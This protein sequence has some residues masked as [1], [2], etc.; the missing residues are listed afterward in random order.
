[1]YFYSVSEITIANTFILYLRTF[2][3]DLPTPGP[4]LTPPLSCIA[5]PAEDQA[6][7]EEWNHWQGS[8]RRPLSP[9]SSQRT[10]PPSAAW[11]ASHWSSL[12]TLSQ[13]GEW[14]I[15]K[16]YYCDPSL[17]MD[18]DYVSYLVFIKSAFNLK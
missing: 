10:T 9:G 17:K 13:D 5:T 12:S 11:P 14:G 18:S 6:Q 3:T 7:G 1:M 2:L 4:A 15:R 8:P 16:Y